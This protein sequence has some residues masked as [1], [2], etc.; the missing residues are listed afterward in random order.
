MALA[1]R[2]WRDRRTLYTGCL[3]TFKANIVVEYRNIANL[4]EEWPDDGGED[5]S[6]LERFGESKRFSPSTARVSFKV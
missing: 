3:E 2:N 5:E 4:P 1:S 6:G